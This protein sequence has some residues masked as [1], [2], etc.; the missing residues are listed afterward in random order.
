MWKRHKRLGR[1]WMN[2]TGNEHQV[3]VDDG[4]GLLYNIENETVEMD[5]ET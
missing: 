1:F 4:D 2:Y 3:S 5:E